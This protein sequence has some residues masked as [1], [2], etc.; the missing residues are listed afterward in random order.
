MLKPFHKHVTAV[1]IHRAVQ[2]ICDFL[3]INNQSV[4]HGNMFSFSHLSLK[5]MQG[6][7]YHFRDNKTQAQITFSR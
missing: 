5:T 1:L 3:V 7:S 6:Y 4:K 2:N